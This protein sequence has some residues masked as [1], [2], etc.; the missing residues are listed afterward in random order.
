MRVASPLVSK[1]VMETE[2]TYQSQYDSFSK[3]YRSV[4]QT[5][6]VTRYRMQNECRSEPVTRTETHWEYT[7]QTRFIPPRTEMLV[8]RR[9]TETEPVCHVAAEGAVS[10]VEGKT[11]TAKP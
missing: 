9:L 1:P 4:P 6:S 3:S 7:T 11:Y 5:R 8:E 2:T 10:R